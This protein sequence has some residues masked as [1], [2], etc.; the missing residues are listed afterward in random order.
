MPINN[1][2][3][4]EHPTMNGLRSLTLDE[5][6]SDSLSTNAMTCVNMD[7]HYFSINFIEADNIQVDKELHLTNNGFIIVGKDTETEVIITDDELKYLSGMTSNIQSQ[8]DFIDNDTTDIVNS[9]NIIINDVSNNTHDISANN[10]AIFNLQ[11]SDILQRIDISNN[12]EEIGYLIT[13]VDSALIRLNGHDTAIANIQAL[14]IVQR[15]DINTNIQD[16][17][18][19]ILRLLAVEVKTDAIHDITSNSIRTKKESHF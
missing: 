3:T 4:L 16:I 18:F 10:L 15:N 5:I 11:A 19:T 13:D 6:T 7:A 8:I 12:A 2:Q 9:I 14:D 1:I 17:G